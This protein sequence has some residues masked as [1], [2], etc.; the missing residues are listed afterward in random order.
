MGIFASIMRSWHENGQ[1]KMEG[2]Y[3]DGKRDGL[4]RSWH[5]NGRLRYEYTYKDGKYDGR[6]RLWVEDGQPQTVPTGIWYE[7]S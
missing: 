4:M 7:S 5:E 6:S 1:L 2:T 3:K